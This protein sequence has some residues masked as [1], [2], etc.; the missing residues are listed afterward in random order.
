ML[1]CARNDSIST[2]F[3]GI[4]ALV[5]ILVASTTTFAA[6]PDEFS[7]TMVA[8]AGGITSTAKIYHAADRTRIE[9][10]GEDTGVA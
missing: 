3:V 1:R 9:S 4:A 8:E 6:G 7:A 5:V 2:L 10:G